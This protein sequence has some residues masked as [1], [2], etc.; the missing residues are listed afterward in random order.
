MSPVSQVEGNSFK[1]LFLLFLNPP[2]L[3]PAQRQREFREILHKYFSSVRDHMIKEH[4]AMHQR[5]RRNR[6][7][8]IS[9]GEISEERRVEN[10]AAQKAYDKLLTSTSTL[11]VSHS[12]SLILYWKLVPAKYFMF[13]LSNSG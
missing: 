10:E 9:K 4:K 11:A 5:E 1:F 6:D 8:I 12:L 13:S 3:I 2:Q 7:I